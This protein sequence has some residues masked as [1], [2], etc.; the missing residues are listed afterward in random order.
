MAP[1]IPT[2]PTPPP[3]PPVVV[4]P[5]APSGYGTPP[6]PPPP[7]ADPKAFSAGAW[8]RIGGRI[9][10]P[11][12]PNDLN[13][14]WLNE[15]YVIAALRGQMTDW[16]KW[17]VNL[18]G[19]IP[20]P[21][22]LMMAPSVSTPP[23][24]ATY[25]SIGI[26]DLI[27]KVEPDELFN[28]WVGRMIVP[29]DR[30]DLSGPWFINYWTFPG[31]FGNR[32]GPPV[33]AKT[34]Q[35]GRDNGLTAWGQVQKGR[36]KYYLGAF[37]LDN[38]EHA[39][40]PLVTARAV[41]NLLDPEPGYYNQ[42]AYHGDKDILAIA[43]GLQY[44]KNG[45]F[46]PTRGL[47]NLTIFEADLL[48]DKKL[49]TAGVGT[50]EASGFFYDERQPIRRFFVLGA[51]YVTPQPIGVGR[52]CPAVRY[53]FTQDAAMHQFD[54]YVS[55]LIKSHF[56]KFFAGFFYADYPDAMTGAKLKSKAIQFGVQLIKF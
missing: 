38:R 44:Q 53:Q 19:N 9:Q 56:A 33:G 6:A 17:Q 12:S 42:T 35:Q 41:L 31:F 54:V 28:V 43:G 21:G 48:A 52:L 22:N 50:L 15:L 27:A 2:Q 10:N 46:S 36:F 45:A 18:N 16:L 30:A 29:L 8:M 51:G 49:G 11:S 14:F 7:V 34:S 24:P 32:P 3:P 55:Y 26:Q 37:N 39:V 25:P 40:N 4:P 5:P 47:G 23:P 13:D 20:P 1:P